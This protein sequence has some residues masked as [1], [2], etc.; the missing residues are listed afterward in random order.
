MAEYNNN[1]DDVVHSSVSHIALTHMAI[2]DIYG[3]GQGFGITFIHS[4]FG[5]VG[6]SIWWVGLV[7][8]VGLCKVDPRPSLH[9]TVTS[10]SGYN[11]INCKLNCE[12]NQNHV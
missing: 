2:I 11:C 6:S 5:C 9:V 10:S 12:S 8:R 4:G 7:G 1:I 3:R